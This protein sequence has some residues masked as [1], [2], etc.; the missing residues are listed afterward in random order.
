MGYSDILAKLRKGRGYTQADAADFISGRSAKAYTFKNISHW[1]TG[2]S[3]PPVEQF[4]L[5]CELYGVSDIQGTFRGLRTELRGL[6]RLNALG[7]SRTEEYIAMLSQNPVFTHEGVEARGGMES[8]ADIWAR[9]EIMPHVG[10]DERGQ[11]GSPLHAGVDDS[12][13]DEPV[14]AE[15]PTER[16]RFIRLYDIPAAAG[17]GSFLDGDAYEDFEVDK[18]VPAEA[19]YAV[20]IRGDSMT[21]RFVDGQIVF[22]KDQGLLE[23]GDIGIFGLDGDAYIKKLGHGTLLSLNERYKPIA[24]RDYQ[25]FH[26]FGKVVG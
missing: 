22:V 1:E 7:L 10:A 18:T 5:L 24:I 21:P 15:R 9:T 11:A 25:S 16:R 13:E 26:I 6:S 23:T 2:V 17:L 12:P 19:D 20:R 4:L 3:M 8:G 14:I